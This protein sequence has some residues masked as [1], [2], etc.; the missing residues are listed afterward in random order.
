MHSDPCYSDQ[1]LKDFNLFQVWRHWVSAKHSSPLALRGVANQTERSDTGK[2]IQPW[3]YRDDTHLNVLKGR[4]TG[5]FST[6]IIAFKAGLRALP[7]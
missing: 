7:T 3:R 4:L 2:Q 1:S 6:L 5:L